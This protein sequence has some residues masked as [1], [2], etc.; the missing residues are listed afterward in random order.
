MIYFLPVVLCLCVLDLKALNKRGMIVTFYN[1][2]KYIPQTLSDLMGYVSQIFKKLKIPMTNC[3]RENV[4]L[5]SQ[6]RHKCLLPVLPF[7]IVLE[8]LANTI[9]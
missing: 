2:R 4:L 3:F 5:E 7:H 1:A 8:V 6:I 9:Q